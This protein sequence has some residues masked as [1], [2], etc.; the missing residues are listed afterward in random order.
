M[1]EDISKES[2]KED[3]FGFALYRFFKVFFL[4]IYTVLLIAMLAG[5]EN[6][7][8]DDTLIILLIFSPSFYGS[9]YALNKFI[10]HAACYIYAGDIYL[11]KKWRSILLVVLW[12]IPC[13]LLMLSI[14]SEY[15]SI[16]NSYP[17]ARVGG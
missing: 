16:F 6:K 14:M 15:L 8:W 1:T 17:R 7:N 12:G 5:R 4:V 11:K 9:L 2:G 10:N 13:I 3:V